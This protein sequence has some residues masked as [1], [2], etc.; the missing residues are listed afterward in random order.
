M[1]DIRKAML[2]DSDRIDVRAGD[3]REIWRTSMS[4]PAAA[5]ERAI[6]SSERAWTALIDGE[7][8]C[9]FGVVTSSLVTARGS[10]WLLGSDL[11]AEY[12]YEFLGHSRDFL[13]RMKSG[14]DGL[15]NYVDVDNDVSITWL[16]WLGFAFEDEPMP[17]GILQRPFL[18][19]SMG[20]L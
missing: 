16:K 1:V 6:G 2:S 13:E 14:Y 9:V 5:I 19:F 11:I 7:I 10:P 18:K 20:A 3:C 12:P 17:Y 4:A 15:T 8:M